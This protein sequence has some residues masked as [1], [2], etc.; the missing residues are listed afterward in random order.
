MSVDRP[1]SLGELLQ[2][3]DISRLKAEAAKRR[4]LAAR[5]RAELPEAEAEHVVSAH[6][7]DQGLLVIGMDSPAWAAR[8]RYS[9]AEL[10]GKPLKV[11]TAVPPGS[12]V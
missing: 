3:G 12:S 9:T 4:E 5:V 6:F 10:L 8:L 1:R 11:R 7:D 2:S